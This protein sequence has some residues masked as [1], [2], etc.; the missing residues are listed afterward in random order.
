MYRISSTRSP[1]AVNCASMF[2]LSAGSG[3]TVVRVSL[4]LDRN[5]AGMYWPR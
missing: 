4:T 3:V 2:T 5:F 1:R